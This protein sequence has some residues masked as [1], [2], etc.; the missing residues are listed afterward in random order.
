M[1]ATYP[2]GL[3]SLVHERDEIR[4]DLYQRALK[5]FAEN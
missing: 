2:D 4:S 3:H 1:G 5:F